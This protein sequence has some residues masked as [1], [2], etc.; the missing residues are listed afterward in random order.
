MVKLTILSLAIFYLIKSGAIEFQKIKLMFK[1]PWSLIGLF[2]LTMATLI[3]IFRWKTLLFALDFQLNLPII[4]KL[5]FIGFAYNLLIPGS[6]SGDLMKAYYLARNEDRKLLVVSTIILDRVIGILSLFSFFILSIT[7]IA[8]NNTELFITGT[9]LFN[10]KDENIKILIIILLLIIM[11]FIFL[12]A[13]KNNYLT[14]IKIYIPFK[15]SL[16]KVANSI[17]LYRNK[18]KAI[19]TAYFISIVGQIPLILSFFFFGKA[20]HEESFHLIHYFLLVP[21]SMML[22]AI[23][24]SPG[25]LGTGELFTFKLFQV[26]GSTNGAN[27]MIL[28]HI[29]TI[30]FGLI[31]LIVILFGIPKESDDKSYN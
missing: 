14:R 17:T 29:G 15:S 1:N 9:Q 4:A 6:V 11:L 16:Y 13:L 10:V 24:I 19:S 27:V 18:W 22:T 26:F 8:F 25:G 2:F 20:I 5:T 31:G 23:P 12:W 3:S 28:F 7:Y 21:I 30:I